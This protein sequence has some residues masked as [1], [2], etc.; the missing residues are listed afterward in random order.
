M[1]STDKGDWRVFRYHFFQCPC[2]CAV[3]QEIWEKQLTED[4]LKKVDGLRPIAEELGCSMAQLALAWAASN[5]DV[6]TVITGASKPQ[7]ARPI[8]V[9]WV[10][11]DR[12]A[13]L[14]C[15][16]VLASAAAGMGVQLRCELY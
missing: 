11:S 1:L 7:Q 12:L 2:L 8:Q 15:E 3:V 14:Y 13:L 6:S 4:N 10:P 5:P 9:D 16:D